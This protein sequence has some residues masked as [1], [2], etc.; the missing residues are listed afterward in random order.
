MRNEFL[1]VLQQDPAFLPLFTKCIL[2][3]IAQGKEPFSSSHLDS[4]TGA[5]LIAP[6]K[7]NGL[8]LPV[9]ISDMFR[10]IVTSYA[11]AKVF[12]SKEAIY[13]IETGA[14]RTDPRYA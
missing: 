8:P 14:G 5:M 4:C 10:A 12:K 9:Q 1:K 11:V 2:C 6:L 7:P 3:G 13:F